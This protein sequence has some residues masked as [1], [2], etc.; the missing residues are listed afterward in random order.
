MQYNAKLLSVENGS[1]QMVVK[2]QGC[3]SHW[4]YCYKQATTDGRI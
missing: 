4:I 3:L 2:V 1:L